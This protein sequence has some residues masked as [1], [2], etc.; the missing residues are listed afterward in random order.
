M[1]TITGIVLMFVFFHLKGKLVI[2]TI[3]LQTG[4]IIGFLSTLF[5]TLFYIPGW[6]ELL[7]LVTD[8]ACGDFSAIIRFFFFKFIGIITW[9]I[10]TGLLAII[11]LAYLKGGRQQAPLD[12]DGKHE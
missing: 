7:K 2:S 10:N 12:K 8:V 6:G 4:I 1:F 3:M 11:A 5:W 9:S